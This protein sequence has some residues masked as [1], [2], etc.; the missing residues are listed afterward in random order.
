MI[1]KQTEDRF[2][3]NFLRPLRMASGVDGLGSI[4]I[5]LLRSEEPQIAPNSG[6]FSRDPNSWL[7]GNEDNSLM[8]VGNKMVGAW[9]LEPQT[10]AVS[11][12][13]STN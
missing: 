8:G 6:K 3:L 1:L 9:G 12:Q 11:R 13:R 4:N 7:S 2:D 10:S 5:A